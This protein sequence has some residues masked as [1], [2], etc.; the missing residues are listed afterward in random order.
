MGTYG[1]I[2]SMP[3]EA[4]EISHVSDTALMTAACRALETE[5]PDGLIRDSFAARLAGDRGMAILR[6][7]DRMEIMCFGIAMRSRYLDQLVLDT[8][9]GEGI[10]TV[11][12]VGAG[13]DT[14]PWRL[15]LPAA[16]RWIEVD[17][18]AMLDYKDSVMEGIGAKCR[19]ERLA[20]DV[21]EASGR[22]SV[23]AAACGGPTLMITE[24]LLMYLPAASIDALAANTAVSHW[25]LDAVSA[26]VA[27][28]M[29]MD[30]Y[31]AIENVRAADHL[32][33]AQILA[34]L[35][36]HGW[37]DIRFI[38]YSADV[39]QIAAERVRNMFRNVP[40]E[41]IPKPMAPGDPSGV[42]LF[43]RP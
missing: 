13:L 14:R 10:R 7:I 38:S 30:S 9:A 6:A 21:N 40:P 27:R 5:R 42:H 18:P 24:G 36:Q 43:G 20:A 41:Q 19:R 34:V 22:E 26:E 29:R 33:G 17:F 12:S 15:E 4:H 16:L 37:T 2:E 1:N 32:D 11:L 23:F 35:R 39:M 25:I 8:V 31:Q 3:P 28:R